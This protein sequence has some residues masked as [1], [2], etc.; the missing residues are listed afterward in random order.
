MTDNPLLAAEM[1][2]HEIT[3]GHCTRD[4][5]LLVLEHGHDLHPTT[6]EQF[7]DHAAEIRALIYGAR[8]IHGALAHIVALRDTGRI[9]ADAGILAFAAFAAAVP[10]E[11]ATAVRV[12]RL[13]ETPR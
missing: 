2:A 13:T 3:A 11:Q 5:A 6:A 4:G 8:L 12:Y 7:L 1:L 9:S 10:P